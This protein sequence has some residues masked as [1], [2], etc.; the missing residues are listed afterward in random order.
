LWPEPGGVKP[1]Q[2]APDIRAV[3]AA[4]ASLQRLDPKDDKQR[5]LKQEALGLVMQLGELRNLLR[6]QA[7]PSISMPVLVV[8]VGW[9][10]VIFVSFSLLAPSNHTVAVALVIAAFS[11]S[12]AI[13]LMLELDRPFDGLVRI[14]PDPLNHVRGEK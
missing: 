3:E 8:V 4:Y 14:P 5:A 9:L 2:G 1:T 6:A 12:A 10:A 11:V 13:F 7:L